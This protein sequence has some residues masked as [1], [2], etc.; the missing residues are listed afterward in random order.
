MSIQSLDILRAR[1]EANVE[2]DSIGVEAASYRRHW[3]VRVMVRRGCVSVDV[4]GR[5]TALS[6]AVEDAVERLH[7]AGVD[8]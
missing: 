2:A 3:T 8:P 1:L 7:D 5:S 6:A 4:T